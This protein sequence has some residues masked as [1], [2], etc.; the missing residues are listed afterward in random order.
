M[1]ESPSPAVSDLTENDTPCTDLT[2]SEV[3]GQQPKSTID[4]AFDRPGAAFVL[5]RGGEKAPPIEKSWQEKPHSYV[6]AEQHAAD[7]GNVAFVSGNGHV[8]LDLDSP[9][10][11]VGVELPATLRWETRPGRLGMLFAVK[12]DIPAT[13]EA[14]GKKPDIAQLKLFRDGEHVG[15][16]KLQRAYQVIPP[17]W[18]I[19]D[20]RR[21]DYRLIDGR[22][23]AEVDIAVLVASLRGAGISFSEK[24]DHRGRLEENAARLEQIGRED[25]KRRYARAALEDEAT[26][27]G[28]SP[29]GSRNDRLNKAAYA[30]GQL[31]ASGA[32]S[33]SEVSREL[34]TAAARAGLDGD[35]I[36]RT[37][38]SGLEAGRRAPRAGP[39]AGSESS[40][41]REQGG[42]SAGR[43]IDLINA[44]IPG[45]IKEH[46]FKTSKDT[47]KIYHYEH[48]VYLDDGEVLLESLIEK[49]F[50]EYTSNKLI[51]DV[52][53]KVKRRTYIDRDS[54]NAGHFLNVENGILDLD[55]LELKPHT[56]DYLSTA[57]INVA[58]DENAKAPR[59][60]KFLREVA[61]PE[62][63]ALIEEIIGW[64]LWPDYNIHVAV[65]LLGPGRN[66]KGT[67]LRLIT[68]FLGP[69]SI[70]NVTL[71]DL[72]AD[73]FAKADLYGKMA[74]IGGDLPAKDLSDTAAFRN[75]TGGDDNRAQEK[76]RPAFN[77]RNKAKMLFSAN[78]LPRSP[79]DSYAYYARWILLEFLHTFDPRSGTGD[80]DLDS[81][82][83]TPEELSG[84]LNIALAGLKR[85]RANGWRF[86]YNKSVEDV[87]IMYK[88]NANAVLAFLMD[89]C[90]EDPEA[91]VEKGVLLS[92]FRRYCEKHGIRPITVTRFGNLLKDQSVIPISDYRPHDP[93][94]RVGLPRCWLGLKF[95]DP[96]NASIPSIVLPNPSITA[97]GDEEGESSKG[98]IG[99][100]GSVD[101]MDAQNAA[102]RE[103]FK[104]KAE[105]V[106]KAAPI[107]KTPL[108][109]EQNQE[110]DNMSE[111]PV[112][113]A[114]GLLATPSD[115]S[116]QSVECQALGQDGGGRPVE[117]GG[118]HAGESEHPSR[119]RPLTLIYEPRGAALEYAQLAAN[120]WTGC[121]HGCS[122]C[123]GPAAIHQ[124][125][126]EYG[127]PKLKK[128]AL[129]RLEGDLAELQRQG[130]KEPVLLM[131]AGD[132]YSP[133]GG[134]FSLSRQV[135][136]TFRKHGSPF[137]VLSKSGLPATKDFDLYG[138]NDSY[139]T[140]LTFLDPAKSREWEP[141]AATPHDRLESLRI[142][143]E[144]GIKTWAS[145]EPVIEPAETLAV[146]EAAAPY[147]DFF[148]V[149]KWNHDARAN[150][151]DWLRFKDDVVK[152]LEKLGKPYKLKDDLLKAGGRPAGG[153]GQVPP[154][155]E[156]PGLQ[157]FKAA[158]AR[159]KCG[160]CGK[161][162]PHDLAPWKVDGDILSYIC[163]VCRVQAEVERGCEFCPASRGDKTAA[164]CKPCFYVEAASA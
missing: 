63:V 118:H 36:E 91:Y 104:K 76:Y 9:E 86:S 67:L 60:Q 121:S 51:A 30:L 154:G 126:E 53:G 96:S 119:G 129:R 98:E 64:L 151:I 16:L 108:S 57:Q 92:R 21:V 47:G 25:R 38:R 106:E 39:E 110:H 10:A 147:T 143:H 152:L 44:R 89:E 93:T 43:A 50:S 65:M 17:S 32:L 112:G 66:G 161:T 15:E 37:L 74:N 55:T 88:R 62:D 109:Q 72:V 148:A 150:S 19:V 22:P 136:Q 68:A 69:K 70:A 49:E 158:I 95:K 61:R 139:G 157:E 111:D 116:L 102:Q 14:I 142:A 131:F 13:L 73:R 48:G 56:P 140:T 42:S 28:R 134:D 97:K 146:I 125:R 41:G 122:Y 133:P 83:Q 153:P 23:P 45:W 58:Y 135:L 103:H 127:R 107:A 160:K 7:G 4:P 82:L 35:E 20:G 12:G 3:A 26:E 6:E 31:V 155:E 105:E 101:G 138:P 54:F 123:Y 132:L 29:V 24:G 8:G 162:F 99:Y 90:E 94:G 84:L 164:G 100:T 130:N 149:G 156:P 75:L 159:R 85:L 81:K 59:I 52:V 27:V 128:D 18:K 141:G 124:S 71:Q 113:A 1:C 115:E 144:R 5:L 2:L 34:A 120:L 78:Q 145:C 137:T 77:F 79:D 11:F 46:N 117:A 163:P 33:E 40:P 114:T 87:E 80:P